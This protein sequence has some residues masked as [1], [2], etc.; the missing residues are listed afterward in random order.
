MYYFPMGQKVMIVLPLALYCYDK[1]YPLLKS[2]YQTVSYC[3]CTGIISGGVM[4]QGVPYPVQKGLEKN[5][6]YWLR[7]AFFLGS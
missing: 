2:L 5:D 4:G 3:D 6:S 7:L 1:R